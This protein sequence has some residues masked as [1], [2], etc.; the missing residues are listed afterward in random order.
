MVE[1]EAPA[2]RLRVYEANRTGLRLRGLA[3]LDPAELRPLLILRCASVHT[4][5][6]RAAIDVAWVEVRGG[7][8]RVLAVHPNVRPGRLCAAPR[9]RRAIAALELPAGTAAASGIEP[10]VVLSLSPLG[11][12]GASGIVSRPGAP[13]GPRSND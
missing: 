1:L 4:F 10:G 13:S 6:M 11:A 2:A 5:G 7:R 8:G 9:R 12:A 3:R